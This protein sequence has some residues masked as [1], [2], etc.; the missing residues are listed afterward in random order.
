MVGRDGL[1]GAEV[2]ILTEGDTIGRGGGGDAGGATTGAGIFTG[3]ATG[4]GVLGVTSIIMMRPAWN[5]VLWTGS[6]TVKEK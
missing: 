2:T 1:G 4:R 6:E 5:N 3:G